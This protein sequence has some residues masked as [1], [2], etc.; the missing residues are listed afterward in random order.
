ME[1]LYS[2]HYHVVSLNKVSQQCCTDEHKT[3]LLSGL[4]TMQALLSSGEDQRDEQNKT[5]EELSVPEAYVVHKK[6]AVATA[7]EH[8][9]HLA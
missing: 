3:N 5:P 4:V 6:T 8:T 9:T 2:S 7:T 1:N